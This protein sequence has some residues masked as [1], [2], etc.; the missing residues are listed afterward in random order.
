MHK[1]PGEV[2]DMEG[3]EAGE[4]REVA[5]K[6]R[7]RRV[8]PRPPRSCKKIIT[9][10]YSGKRLLLLLRVHN[11][12]KGGDDNMDSEKMRMD[13]M[14]TCPSDLLQGCCILTFTTTVEK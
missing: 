4:E 11:C 6:F 2:G 12:D 9:Q 1:V 8:S 13:R 7:L 3:E 10:P 5:G 14:L